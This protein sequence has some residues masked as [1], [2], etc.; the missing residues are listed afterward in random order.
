[1]PRTHLRRRFALPVFTADGLTTLAACGGHGASSVSAKTTSTHPAPNPSTAAADTQ[2]LAA[3]R[4]VFA[5][6]TAVEALAS[7][8]DRQN[9]RLGDHLDGDAYTQVY[10]DVFVNTNVNGAAVHGAP[11]LLHPS[12]VNS[13]PS[14]DPYQVLVADCVQTSSWTPVVAAGK[15][16]AA[17]PGGRQLTQALVANLGWTWRDS[18]LIMMEPGSC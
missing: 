10:N 15:P 11:V 18:E 2:S 16:Y 7:K 4:A 12:V 14:A 1:M 17:S 6:W 9:P 5:D 13:T 3:Y 8:S